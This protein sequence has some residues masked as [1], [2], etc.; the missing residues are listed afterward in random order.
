[1]RRILSLF[2]LLPITVSASII[3]L[4]DDKVDTAGETSTIN[5]NFYYLDNNKL[6]IRPSYLGI[7]VG[8]DGTYRYLKIDVEQVAPPVADCG[9]QDKEG[10]LV[11][12]NGGGAGTHRLYICTADGWDYV[13]LTD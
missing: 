8:R 13:T 1:M 7:G 11:L 6:D 3:P 5:Q 10:R 2:L 4:P 9:S 12:Y